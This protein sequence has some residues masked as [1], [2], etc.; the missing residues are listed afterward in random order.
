MKSC[1]R[2]QSLETISGTILMIKR[3]LLEGKC[4]ALAVRNVLLLNT[5]VRHLQLLPGYFA[6]LH[7]MCLLYP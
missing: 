6:Y 1:L 3:I 5:D 2:T 7:F 4:H